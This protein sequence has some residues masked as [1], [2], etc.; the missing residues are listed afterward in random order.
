MEF[1]RQ[2]DTFATGPSAAALRRHPALLQTEKLPKCPLISV[3]PD[4]AHG[5]KMERITVRECDTSGKTEWA[6][7]SETGQRR[8]NTQ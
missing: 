5:N 6:A 7:C 8:R 2:P 4:W 1:H 3:V